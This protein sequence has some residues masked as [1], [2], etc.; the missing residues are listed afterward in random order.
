MDLTYTFNCTFEINEQLTVNGTIE[1]PVSIPDITF[2]PD[3][4]TD[5][6]DIFINN[7]PYDDVA[8]PIVRSSDIM[9]FDFSN[10]FSDLGEY[11][12]D[13][14]T[15]KSEDSTQVS[16]IISNGC[17]TTIFQYFVTVDPY[18]QFLK[19]PPVVFLSSPDFFS[20]ECTLI[21]CDDCESTASSCPDQGLIIVAF[22]YF[23][24]FQETRR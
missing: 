4:V 8:A 17:A 18:G 23:Y 6:P 15:V 21:F 5:Q 16:A 22:S 10:V 1:P 14:C 3:P 13:S 19:T 12:I 24:D 20:I 2:N 7:E 11:R 9:T